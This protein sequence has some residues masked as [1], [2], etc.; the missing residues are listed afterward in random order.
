MLRYS[1]GKR[2]RDESLSELAL[3]MKNGYASVV[4]SMKRRDRVQ[5]PSKS[6]SAPR[7]ERIKN[8]NSAESVSSFHSS[9]APISIFHPGTALQVTV[10]RDLFINVY[11]HFE[12]SSQFLI[13][14]L[15]ITR[16]YQGLLS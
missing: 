11:C 4:Q 9:N 2:I 8:M 12:S 7:F 10:W 1:R 3:T 13:E 6:R 16:Q 14:K 15:R 5:K